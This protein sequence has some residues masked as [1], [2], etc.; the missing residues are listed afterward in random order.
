MTEKAVP[1][2]VTSVQEAGAYLV[3]NL[4]AYEA[5]FLVQKG[6]TRI[7]VNVNGYKPL[8]E[9]TIQ[10]MAALGFYLVRDEPVTAAVRRLTFQAGGE[11]PSTPT[12]WNTTHVKEDPR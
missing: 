4:A 8:S 3:A 6:T 9:D 11:P 5:A 2:W 7:Q 10:K 1:F 12:S